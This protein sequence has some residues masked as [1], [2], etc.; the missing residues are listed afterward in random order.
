MILH[1]AANCYKTCIRV[2]SSLGPDV[3]ISPDHPI[4]AK[5]NP[6]VLGHIH[7]QHYVSLQ[8]RK[9]NDS[10]VPALNN[11]CC[12]LVRI[13]IFLVLQSK[14]LCFQLSYY[15]LQILLCFKIDCCVSGAKL[16][17]GLPLCAA[18]D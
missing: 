2:I 11:A 5:T 7:E 3:I 14:K 16:S 18:V 15:V 6:L 13:K 12:V 9:G 1:A 17:N 8:P 10:Y 4:V